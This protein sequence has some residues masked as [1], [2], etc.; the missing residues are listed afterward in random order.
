MLEDL[1]LPRRGDCMLLRSV[2]TRGSC[3]A[4]AGMV[5]RFELNMFEMRLVA[6]SDEFS[7]AMGVPSSALCGICSGD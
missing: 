4:G 5:A 7:S 2:L 6:L 1:L 3:S